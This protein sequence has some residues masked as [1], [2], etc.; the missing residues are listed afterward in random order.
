MTQLVFK[1]DDFPPQTLTPLARATLLQLIGEILVTLIDLFLN[2]LLCCLINALELVT[3]LCLELEEDLLNLLQVNFLLNSLSCKFLIRSL[4]VLDPS[5]L[6]LQLMPLL[7]HFLTD[8]TLQALRNLLNHL[9][10]LF[11]LFP[12]I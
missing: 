4:Q 12:L 3:N 9:A 7:N 11:N 6:L 10:R 1:H 2:L 5:H 8:F